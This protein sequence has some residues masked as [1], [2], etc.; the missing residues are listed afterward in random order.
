ATES[1]VKSDLAEVGQTRAPVADSASLDAT[2]CAARG[3]KMLPQGRMQS[4]RCVITYADAGRRCT[5]GS[6]CQ[7]DC[8]VEEVAGTPQAG[9]AAVGTCQ[10]DSSRFGCYTTVENGRAEATICVD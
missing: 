1:G 9:A 5:T 3:G 6:D 8:R 2:E 10:R 4:V 7:G